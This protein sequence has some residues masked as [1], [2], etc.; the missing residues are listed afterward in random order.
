MEAVDLSLSLYIYILG[1]RER[2]RDICARYYVCAYAYTHLYI[3]L[4]PS[5]APQ[6]GSQEKIH[7]PRGQQMLDCETRG[8]NIAGTIC[9]TGLNESICFVQSVIF[10]LSSVIDNSWAIDISWVS[11]CVPLRPAF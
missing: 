8:R 2:E 9:S 3:W 10:D 5:V 11:L 7:P 4:F 1:E 6:G